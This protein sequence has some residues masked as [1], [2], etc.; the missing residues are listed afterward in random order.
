MFFNRLNGESQ[1]SCS[2]K[3]Y[4]GYV[5]LEKFEYLRGARPK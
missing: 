4:L 1:I 2:G 5:R 3:V